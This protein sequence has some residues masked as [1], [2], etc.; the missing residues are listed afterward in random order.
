MTE[1]ELNELY[2]MSTDAYGSVLE[3][4]VSISFAVVVASFFTS[5][6]LNTSIIRL[7]AFLY[8]LSSMFLASLYITTS[9]RT[10]HYYREM[11]AAGFA[12]WHLDHPVNF[13]TLGLVL[14]L[15]LGGTI[16]TVYYMYTCVSEKESGNEST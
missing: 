7:M 9:I 8:I 4:W 6:K 2:L 11:A 3:F 13:V 10:Y 5:S 16:G 15:F 14:L 12:T 1:Y